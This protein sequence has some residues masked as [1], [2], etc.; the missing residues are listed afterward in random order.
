[1]PSSWI[2]NRIVEKKNH[3][4]KVSLSKIRFFLDPDFGSGSSRRSGFRIRIRIQV[5]CS[6]KA[7]Y[8]SVINIVF[9]HEGVCNLDSPWR[10]FVHYVYKIIVCYQKPY[11]QKCNGV[12][13]GNVGFQLW[14]KYSYSVRLPPPM[15]K[16]RKSVL[17][18]KNSLQIKP[19]K[20]VSEAQKA[21]KSNGRIQRAGS[22]FRILD[23]GIWD[24]DPAD[25]MTS[26]V[27]RHH[28]FLVSI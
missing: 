1:M 28:L 3:Y 26:L 2:W 18:W 8:C 10:H 11:Q 6:W 21:V 12:K 17:K 16:I 9:P 4:L 23:L 24:P 7:N 5:L 15:L 13:W 14:A 25:P 20:A 22:G 19:F 27:L